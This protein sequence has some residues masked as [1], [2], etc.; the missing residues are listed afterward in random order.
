MLLL[1]LLLLLILILYVLQ[2][3]SLKLLVHTGVTVIAT[4]TMNMSTNHINLFRV[5]LVAGRHLVEKVASSV[6]HDLYGVRC[7]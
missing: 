6:E 2:L 3:P 4:T 1:L 7:L 5:Q